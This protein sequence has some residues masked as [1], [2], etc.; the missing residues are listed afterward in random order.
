MSMPTF[1][2]RDPAFWGVNA[3]TFFFGFGAE[4]REGW[5][6]RLVFLIPDDVEEFF[7]GGDI[8][9]PGQGMPS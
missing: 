4:P 1:M 6:R 7:R 3:T 5:R 2:V 9:V 8:V